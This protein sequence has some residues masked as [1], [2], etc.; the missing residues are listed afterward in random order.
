MKYKNIYTGISVRQEEVLNQLP[1]IS[2]CRQVSYDHV[3]FAVGEQLFCIQRNGEIL[4][5]ACGAWD[6]IEISAVKKM[7]R[8]ENFK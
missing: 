7:I 8:L 3:E 2:K 5:E 6:C 1:G 4:I